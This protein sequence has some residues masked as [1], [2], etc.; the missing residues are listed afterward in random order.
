MEPFLPE[1]NKISLIVEHV[2]FSEFSN[3]LSVDSKYFCVQ[4][5]I[6]SLEAK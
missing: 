1:N 6:I 2:I 5:L 3:P 4:D